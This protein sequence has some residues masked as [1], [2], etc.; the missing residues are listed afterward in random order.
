MVPW[1]ADH[2][3]R[4]KAN[5]GGCR[6]MRSAMADDFYETP[7]ARR[8]SNGMIAIVAL[9]VIGLIALPFVWAFSSWL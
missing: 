3:T 5:G 9:L 2:P 1:R 4:V 7:S 6:S 8:R